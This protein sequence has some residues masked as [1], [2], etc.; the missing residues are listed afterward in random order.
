MAPTISSAFSEFINALTSILA[1]LFNSLMAVFQ[2]IIA[3]FVN[4]FSSTIQLFQ[5]ILKLGID[6]CQGL[7]GFV[8]ANFLALATIGGI[9][10]W[11]TT[12]QRQKSGGVVG[13]RTT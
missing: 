9:Y 4:V 6:M 1:G 8:A 12:S 2:A 13:K 3:F 5:S 10:Y 11:Y 7:V